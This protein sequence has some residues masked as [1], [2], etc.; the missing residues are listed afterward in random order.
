MHIEELAVSRLKLKMCTKEEIAE[1]SGELENLKAARN[2]GI[3]M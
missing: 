1:E 2:S 3:N